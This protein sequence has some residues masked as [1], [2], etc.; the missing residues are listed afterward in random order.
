LAGVTSNYSYDALYE[1]TQVTQGTNTTESY[2]YDPVGN[3]LSSQSVSSYTYNTSNEMTAAGS[4]MYTYDSNGN[5]LT[6]TDSNGTTA[7]AWDFENR[8]ASVTLPGSGG[9]VTFKYDPLGRRIYKQSP[10]ATSIFLYDGDNLTET[11]NAGGTEIT[12][13]AQGLNIDELLAIKG[14]SGTDYYEA[15]GLGSVTSLTAPAGTVAES[16]A[17]DSF[18]NTMS[19]SGSLANS[20]RYTAR[21]FDAETGLYYNRARYYDPSGGRFLSEDPVG[22]RGSVD[23]YAYVENDPVRHRDPSGLIHQAWNEPPFDGR[24]HDDPGAGLEVLCTKG[25]NIERDIVWLEHSIGVRWDEIERLGGDADA[26]HIYRLDAEVETLERCQE[27]HKNE[28]PE[29]APGPE[30]VPSTKPK[31]A[32]LLPTLIGIL[33]DIVEGALA[34][35]GA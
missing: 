26:G 15:D 25:R 14:S 3:R 21:E 2:S 35:A 13:N 33:E 5:T 27:C 18:G 7:Y 16:Y 22:F 29:P 10:S 20:F 11:T 12:A 4:V 8:L 6:R 17:Y 31:G 9:T 30:P 19:S 34:G 24:L 32:P 23:F 1:L 28:K